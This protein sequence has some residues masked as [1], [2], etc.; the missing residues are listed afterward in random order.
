MRTRLQVLF[1]LTLVLLAGMA[2]RAPV[3]ADVGS[4]GLLTPDARYTVALKSES[5]SLSAHHCSLNT[6]DLPLHCHYACNRGAT[7]SGAASV[8]SIK[9]KKS[10]NSKNEPS[11]VATGVSATIAAGAVSIGLYYSIPYPAGAVYKAYLARTMRQ[12]N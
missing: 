1:V 4:T 2:A 9:L 6:S 11:F 3:A 8:R 5:R 12:L 10:S 7:I